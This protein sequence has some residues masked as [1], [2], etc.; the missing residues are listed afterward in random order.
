[1]TALVEIAYSLITSLGSILAPFGPLAW[2]L[3]IAKTIFDLVFIP[4]IN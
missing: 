2:P 1:M 3:W 4:I